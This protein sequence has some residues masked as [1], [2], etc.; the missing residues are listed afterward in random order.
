MQAQCT[1]NIYATYI[2]DDL[3]LYSDYN[4]ARTYAWSVSGN[5]ASITPNG[6]Q[7][8]AHRSANVSTTVTLTTTEGTCTD[9][10]VVNYPPN[11]V[12]FQPLIGDSNVCGSNPVAYEC[13]WYQG[14]GGPAY[15]G[16]N[17]TVVG[18][19]IV[20]RHITPVPPFSFNERTWVSW[21]AGPVGTITSSYTL[22]SFP[23]GTNWT[24]SVVINCGMAGSHD[25]CVGSPETYQQ[26]CPPGSTFT[27]S[28]SHG[29]ILSGQNTNSVQIQW[30]APG[31]DT[32]VTIFN[33]TNCGLDTNYFPITIRNY[34]TNQIGGVTAACE[35][36]I[37]TFG[38]NILPIMS[39]PAVTKIWQITGGGLNMN[40]SPHDTFHYMH[41]PGPVETIILTTIDHG[42][43][44]HDTLSVLIHP[45]PAINLGPDPVICTGDS[46]LLNAGPG[47]N[48]YA[49]STGATN[50]AIFASAPIPYVI[51]VTG[52]AFNC[53]AT[54][55]VTPTIDPDCVWP[56]DA[57]HDYTVD[58]NDF[59]DIG[60]AFGDTGPVRPNGFINWNGQPAPDWSNN[61]LSGQNHKHA[62]C[63]GN[64][65]VDFPDTIAVSL[66]QGFTHL[67]IGQVEG[68]IPL[69]IR[70]RIPFFAG[71]DT[72][73]LIVTLGN[74]G[75]P[76]DTGYGLA[77]QLDF[78]PSEVYHGAFAKVS[79]T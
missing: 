27:W 43:V 53:P 33:S 74:P 72:V 39:P 2:N 47:Y 77:F 21:G 62:D 36:T 57:N 69:R 63:D 31:T 18:G 32:I 49:W 59:L 76:A 23:A 13:T 29:T 26:N 68:G 20:A 3:N 9:T 15:Y 8:V 78:A 65:M 79:Y 55:T 25:V 61:F 30:N 42:C 64:G 40:S 37:D 51:S 54:D 11:P 48:S 34:P 67:R 5:G 24:R 14:P 60:V 35:N 17:V 44:S 66:Y 58:A 7:A 46:V 4:P 22:L 75:F 56:G 38:T 71:Q 12:P 28:T 1:A 50:S 10:R 19:T 16:H 45:A 70:P 73:E 52:T 41:G 6:Y